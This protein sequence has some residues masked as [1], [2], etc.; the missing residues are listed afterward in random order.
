MLRAGKGY[1]YEGGTRVPFIVRWPGR[2]GGGQTSDTPVIGQD[3]FDVFRD[4]DGM[5]PLFGDAQSERLLFWH[6]PHYTPQ[7]GTPMSSLRQGDYKLVYDYETKASAL[8]NLTTDPGEESD[9]SDTE[10]ERTAELTRLLQSRLADMGAQ[11]PT[12]L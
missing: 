5:S 11:L 4:P 1:L 3:I 12:P 9:L 6:A 7:G 10:P 8:F 2:I